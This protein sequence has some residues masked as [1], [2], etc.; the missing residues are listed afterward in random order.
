MNILGDLSYPTYLTHLFVI[1]FFQPYA[2]AL[3]PLLPFPGE[4]VT[5]LYLPIVLIS[6]TIAHLVLERPV[7]V[8]LRVALGRFALRPSF[9]PAE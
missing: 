9:A 7:G 6:A 2:V 4:T 3:A 1:P 8:F 5:A